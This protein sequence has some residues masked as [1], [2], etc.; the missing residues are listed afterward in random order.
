M[1]YPRIVPAL[2]V[3]FG[4]LVKSYKFSKHHI[5]GCVITQM[6][7]FKEWDLDEIVIIDITNHSTKN[8]R[9]YKP[10]CGYHFFDLIPKISKNCFTPLSIGG[11]IY[12]L[13]DIH[14]YLNL[15]ADR[16]IIGSA[17]FKESN[18]IYK[19][20]KTFGSQAII[21]CLDIK[22]VNNQYYIAKNNGKTIIKANLKEYILNLVDQGAGEV[23][24][25]YVD[26][27]GT[28]SGLD[29]ILIKKIVS[30][31]PIPVTILGGANKL[32]DFELAINN[33]VNGVS[34]GNYFLFK[35]VSYQR[36]KDHLFKKK[37]ISRKSNLGL[38]YRKEISKP[39]YSSSVGYI[40]NRLE[41][42]LNE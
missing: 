6:N 15:G 25:N 40:F 14:N 29:Q 19:S 28:N 36:L 33:G 31:C 22:K 12:T 37:I 24:I 13:K 8:D 3:K 34:A 20:A 35:E 2:Y 27:D 11:G 16:V 42:S 23:L 32:I 1:H 9:N 7:R 39:E 41:K 17:I 21:I 18:L 38:D 30:F 26:R 4:K 10:G 5:L